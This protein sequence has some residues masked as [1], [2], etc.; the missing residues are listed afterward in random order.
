MVQV[1]VPDWLTLLRAE[2]GAASARLYEAAM[3]GD[4]NE[5][6]E[7]LMECERVKAVLALAERLAKLTAQEAEP[8][9]PMFGRLDESE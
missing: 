1:L 9:R 7:Y 4:G 5:V 2:Q 8:P 6:D 3:S